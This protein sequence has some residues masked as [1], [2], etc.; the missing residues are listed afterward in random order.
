MYSTTQLNYITP[1][2]LL[3]HSFS[4]IF[5]FLVAGCSQ[6][7]KPYVTILLILSQYYL[8]FLPPPSF[9]FLSLEAEEQNVF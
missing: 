9:H 3:S 8:S 7:F 5:P 1:L 2:M 4:L 6:N